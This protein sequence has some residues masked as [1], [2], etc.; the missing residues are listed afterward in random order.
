MKLGVNHAEIDDFRRPDANRGGYGDVHIS[1][2]R[3]PVF[4]ATA[5]A[6]ADGKQKKKK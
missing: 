2:A 3:R 5:H 6:L 1:S 4:P